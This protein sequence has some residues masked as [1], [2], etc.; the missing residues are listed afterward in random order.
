QTAVSAPLRE[1]PWRQRGRRRRKRFDSGGAGPD[2]QGM[3]A[4]L[5]R[6]RDLLRDQERRA[7]RAEHDPVRGSA[8]G[9]RDL[10]RPQ[11]PALA[12]KAQLGI[13]NFEFGIW[14]LELRTLATPRHFG[15]I[16][17]S[18]FIILNYFASG[19]GLTCNF[20]SLLVV[21]RPP[22]MWKGAR[23]EMLVQI[24]LPFHPALA[25]SMRPSIPFA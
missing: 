7:A 16:P 5:E 9:Q 1:L 22:S 24:P 20:T 3:E 21:P 18:K 17:N 15:R 11:L 4:R 10:E 6:R 14:N 25:S 8:E 2:R 12:G 19:S 23:V 13:K